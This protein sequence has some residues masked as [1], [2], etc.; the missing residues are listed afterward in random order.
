M[1]KGIGHIGIAVKNIE[2]TLKAFTQ[3]LNLP[4][5]P[6]KDIPERKMKVAVVNLGG[7]GLELIQDDSS[8]GEFAT[9]VKERGNC[10]HHFC[11]LT[12]EIESDI[13]FLK[14]RGVEMAD[15]KPKIGVRGK[16]IAF[17]KKN[18]LGGIALEFSEP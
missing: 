10:I 2:E 7:V 15:E 6:I 17:A 4:L 16:R 1:I 5:P 12:D 9:L 18:L 3:A 13:E 8:D 11:L 14:N